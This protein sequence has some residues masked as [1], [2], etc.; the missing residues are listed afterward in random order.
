MNGAATRRSILILLILAL[1]TL[2]AYAV[3]AGSDATAGFERL[4]S[5]A[6]EWH[7]TGPHGRVEISYEVI[8]GG[9]A[10]I[11]RRVPEKEPGMTTVFHLD[12]DKLMMTHYCSIGNQPRMVAD[13]SKTGKVE[14]LNFTFL[15]VTNLARPTDG[16]MR[17]L[18]F[19]F[20][21]KDHVTQG[22]TWR[23]DD[24]DVRTTFE[25][26]RKTSG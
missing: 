13:V 22:W 1:G 10:V 17:N 20:Q 18:T 12:G 25:L 19:T 16:H 4:K 14:K 7:A 3:W 5:L 2:P 15:D 21:G 23:Q 24:K 26:E 11:E 9:A 8:S 6:G